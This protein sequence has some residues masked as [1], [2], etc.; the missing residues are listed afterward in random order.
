MLKA[1]FIERFARFSEWPHELSM[2]TFKIKVI[3]HSPFGGALEKM[4][5]K[6]KVQDRPVSIEYVSSIADIE[7]CQILFISDS[8]SKHVESI[9]NQVSSKPVLTIGET[10]GYIDKGVIVNFY[11]T[12]KGTV[13]FEISKTSIKNSKVKMDIKLL[14]YAKLVE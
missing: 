4:F 1:G 12:S 7:D 5:A 10:K 3:G 14:G 8:E 2:D 6:V 11:E 13:H 9:I